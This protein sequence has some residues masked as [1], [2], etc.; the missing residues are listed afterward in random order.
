MFVAAGTTITCLGAGA[1]SHTVNKIDLRASLGWFDTVTVDLTGI[2]PGSTLR[3]KWG[4]RPVLVRRRFTH[5]ILSEQAV[6]PEEL[7]D[8]YARNPE[9]EKNALATDSNRVKKGH[10]QWLVVTGLCTHMGCSLTADYKEQVG[11][12]SCPCHGARYDVSGRVRSGPAP[13]NL[14]IPPYRFVSDTLIE[15]G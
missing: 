14:E 10:E 13:Q 5:E 9:L 2:S 4:Q 15:L 8:K 1:L 3:V 12:W 6:N 7:L 11:G